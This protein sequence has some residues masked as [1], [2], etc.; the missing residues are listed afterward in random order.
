M[1]SR[2]AASGA[3]NI[4]KLVAVVNLEHKVFEKSRKFFLG[5]GDVYF[6]N[7]RAVI[8]AGEMMLEI[9]YLM[10]VSIGRVIDAVAEPAD[11]VNHRNSHI[12]DFVVF[13]VVVA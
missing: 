6:K 4:Y 12:L 13:A 11:S 9:E 5:D 3:L 2:R 8:E 1:V 7:S 10:I